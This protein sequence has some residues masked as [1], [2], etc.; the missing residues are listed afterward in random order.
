MSAVPPICM[1]DVDGLPC[2]YPRGHEGGHR[3]VGGWM[4]VEDVPI[5]CFVKGLGDGAF[6]AFRRLSSRS[7][8]DAGDRVILWADTGAFKVYDPGEQ[9][10]TMTSAEADEAREAAE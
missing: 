2:V 6:A 4:A 3:A 9:V 8:T 1:A 5:G 7:R 10:L